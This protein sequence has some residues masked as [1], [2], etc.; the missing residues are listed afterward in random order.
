M[1]RFSLFSYLKCFRQEIVVE[2]KK[3]SHKSSNNKF[4]VI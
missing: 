3:S 4:M 1:D 2:K